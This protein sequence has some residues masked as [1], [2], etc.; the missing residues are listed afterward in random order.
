MNTENNYLEINKNSWNKKTESHLTSEFYDVE[1]F[2]NGKS[3]LNEIELNL[4]GDLKGKSVLHLQCHFGQD[5]ISLSRLGA[6]ATGIDLSDKAIESAD[7]LAIEANSDAQFICSDVYDLPNHL[8]GEFDIVYT[9]Y[10]T[11]GWLPDLDKW[12]KV[13]SKFLKPGGR[14]IF[15]EFHPVVWMFDDNFEK[16]GYRYFNSGAIIETLSGTY[17]DKNAD[18]TQSYVMW[19][20]DLSE[21]VNSLIKNGLEINSLDEFDYSPYNCFNHTIE[22][23]PNKYRISHLDNKIPMVYSIAA[24]K[25]DH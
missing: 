1:G 7:K 19:N 11:I 8:Q 16:V 24:T 9:S 21:V 2:L 22:F 23:E 4:L 18:I 6:K 3:S 12:A 10:G 17:A 14:F 25:K 13:I 15:V 5:T 20:H